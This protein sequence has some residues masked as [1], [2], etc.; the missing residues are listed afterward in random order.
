MNV[1]LSIT[2]IIH[3]ITPRDAISLHYTSDCEQDLVLQTSQNSMG[4]D[5]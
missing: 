5:A 3:M 4:D 1:F 2:T